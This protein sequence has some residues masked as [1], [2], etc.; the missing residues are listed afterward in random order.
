M[1]RPWP[2]CSAAV[3]LVLLSLSSAPAMAQ[4]FSPGPLARAHASL[5]GLEKCARC[6]EENKGLSARLCLDCHTEL[7][8]R[9]GRGLGFHG[10][11][12]AAKKQDC[13]GCHP[14]H[15][16]LDLAMIDWEGQREA[17]DHQR[18]G[19]PLTGAHSKQRCEACHQR[20][21]IA[22]PAI[23]RMLEK[24]P[25]RTTFLG[26]STRCDA[27]HFDEHRGQLARECQRCHNDTAW[28]P[29]AAFNHQTT[30]FPLRRKHR[31]VACAKC[32]PSIPDDDLVA[33]QIPKPRAAS[34]MQ[35]K[36]VEH[37]T[38]E[39][40]HED[41]HKGNLGPNCAGCHSEAGWKI[42]N[43]SKGQDTTFHDKTKFPLRGAH[44]AV[45]CKSCHGPFPGQPARFKGL[46]SGRCSDC[47]EDAHLGQLRAKTAA[48]VVACEGCHT[49]NAFT[50]ARYERE[51]HQATR[52]P[53]DG[54]H[55]AVACRGCHPIDEGLTAR[56]PLAV[57]QRLKAHLRV[58]RFSLAVLH[59]KK[60]PQACNGCHEDVHRGQFAGDGGAVRAPGKSV[61]KSPGSGSGNAAI[62][63]CVQCHRTTSFADLTFDHDKDSRFPLTGKHAEA[64]CGSCHRPTRAAARTPAGATASSSTAGAVAPSFV[65]Y[66]P[67]DLACASC[68]ADYHQGQF[69]ASA[70][71]TRDADDPTA[72]AQAQPPRGC[73]F[74]HKTT[75]F[76]DSLFSHNEPRFSSYPLEGKHLQVACARCHP[77]VR[78][79]PEVITVRYRP[80]PRGC[81]DCHADFHHGEFRGF[82]P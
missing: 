39:S 43:A 28:K 33:G 66:R 71:V 17:F 37:D 58:G 50:P 53:L 29:V 59:P 63:N 21:L 46:A 24:E 38:C 36:P 45:A 60:S 26:A 4:F 27:C 40:C 32:H 54:A 9:V 76:Q 70:D 82:E 3:L 13:Q 61:G 75:R 79:A 31:D 23:R 77:T 57:R 44:V 73:D 41:P 42:I 64:R 72:P 12:P 10:R 19:W 56:V 18:T 80:M 1:R 48:E 65:R 5:E 68:H 22:D 6:H 20:P 16:G 67:L 81:E 47:H 15:R 11:L 2:A 69:L 74:C 34:F 14:D 52:F 35:M 55:G 30:D 7:Q 49:V 78:P 51:Q 25:R 62:D 8:A